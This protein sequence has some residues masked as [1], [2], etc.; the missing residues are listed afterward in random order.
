ML[1]RLLLATTLIGALSVAATAQ[2][3]SKY[4]KT[5]GQE[6]Y[7]LYFIKPLAF[8]AGK[9]RLVPDF[10]FQYRETPPEEVDLK[11]SFFSKKPTRKMDVL[12]FYSGEEA[13]GQSS[14]PN[15][16]FLEQA[17]G[18]WHTRFNASI[19]YST[20][21]KMLQ[22]GETLVIRL[23]IGEEELS[24]PAGKKWDKASAVLREI[25]GAEIR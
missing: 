16:M 18:R 14:I 21:M 5:M 7:T 4:L 11:F 25:L 2:A 10:T 3:S 12:S 19:P 24:F 13:L 15:L 6:G 9:A 23:H 20:L 22:A 1:L 17:K 8:K